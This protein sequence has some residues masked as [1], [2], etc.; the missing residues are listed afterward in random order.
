LTYRPVT[1]LLG[2]DQIFEH[3]L[4]PGGDRGEKLASPR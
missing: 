3:V 2:L 4:P 1:L